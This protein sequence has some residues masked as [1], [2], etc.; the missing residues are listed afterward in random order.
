MIVLIVSFLLPVAFRL[1]LLSYFVLNLAYNF[2]L[3]NVNLIESVTLAINFVMRVL[4]GCYAIAV[5]PSHWILVIT[6]FLALFLTLI[7]RKS[8]LKILQEKAIL[9]R[10]VLKNYTIDLLNKLIYICA[11]ITLTAYM[12]Y[13]FDTKVMSIFGTDKLIYST[14]FVV[15]GIFRFIQLSENNEYNDEGD[16]TTLLLKDIFSQIIFGLWVAYIILI[17]Y[18]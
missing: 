5:V 2:G 14:I 9:H 4:A 3:K 11:T 6:F 12:L 17:I 18:L 13:T 15:I 7:K 16:P 8:E 1:T 10:K